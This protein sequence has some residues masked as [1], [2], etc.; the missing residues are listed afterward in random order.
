MLGIAKSRAYDVFTKSKKANWS[1]AAVGGRDHAEAD[2][3]EDADVG[4]API[5]SQE[6]VLSNLVREALSNCIEGLPDVSYNRR[7]TRMQLSGFYIGDKYR[8]GNFLKKVEHVGMQCVRAAL[9]IEMNK[10]LPGLSKPSRFSVFFDKVNIE[11]G[12]FGRHEALM[13]IGVCYADSETG[14]LVY[15]L[16]ACPSAGFHLDGLSQVRLI[17]AALKENP[18]GIGMRRLRAGL[19]HTGGDGAV[20]LGGP[21][22]RHSGNKAADLIWA[23]VHPGR[24]LVLSDWDLY[25]RL[26]VADLRSIKGSTRAME[27]TEVHKS[28]NHLFGIGRGKVLLRSVAKEMS[29]SWCR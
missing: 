6:K 26:G 8:D 16:A 22:A 3:N 2:D 18:L 27:V 14:D 28:M 7:L 11:G 5:P 12:I 13:L 10:N 24:G 15:R 25:H 29:R 9:G 17:L 20:V 21:L 23:H 19:A 1:I 4:K